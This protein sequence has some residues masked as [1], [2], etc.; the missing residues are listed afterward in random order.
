MLTKNSVQLVI[1]NRSEI[2][3]CG[4]ANSLSDQKDVDIVGICHTA[5]ELQALLKLRNA[6]VLLLD[7]G[8]EQELLNLIQTLSIQ[9]PKL[10]IL[11]FCSLLKPYIAYQLLGMGIT[12]IMSWNIPLPEI[13]EGVH[14][15]ARGNIVL[16]HETVSSSL[17]IYFC[18]GLNKLNDRELNA[19]KFVANGHTN[20]EIAAQMH[21]TT[22]TVESY[23]AGICAKLNARSR[24]QA[25]VQAMNLGL[26]HPQSDDTLLLS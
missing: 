2:T 4:L 7:L 12:G 25:V 16:K 13:Y 3:T 20:K 5:A 22:R 14:A 10:Q 26:I 15:A 19:L 9:Y 17:I 8:N 1:A 18:E 23:I 6:D 21:V 24:T 11:L